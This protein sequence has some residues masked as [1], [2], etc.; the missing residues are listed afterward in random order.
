MTD[1]LVQRAKKGDAEAFAQLFAHYEVELYKMAYIYVGNEADALDVVQEVAYRS[2]KSIHS[3]QQTIY[4]KTWLIRI[5]INCANDV[6][7]KKGLP[8]ATIHME[9]SEEYE[10]GLLEKWRLEDVMTILSKAEKDIVLLRFYQDYTIAQTAQIL[11][12]KLGTAKT[13]LYRA[14]KKL[15]QALEQEDDV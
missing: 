6:L 7:K 4:V 13:I 9:I 11:Q 15:K 3:L 5:T 14:L 2:F 8:T 12:L 10:E 1:I